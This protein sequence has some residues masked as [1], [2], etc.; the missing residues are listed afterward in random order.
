MRQVL[1]NL[2]TNAVQAIEKS[3]RVEIAVGGKSDEVFVEVT[4]DGPGIPEEDLERIF[5]PFFTT[6]EEG[7]GTGLGLAVSRGIVEKLSGRIEVES[8]PGSGC[9]FRVVL[10]RRPD[11]RRNDGDQSAPRR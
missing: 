8:R 1:L 11:Q 9:T 2:V 5:E 6:K 3:G 10:P 4:D 7:K